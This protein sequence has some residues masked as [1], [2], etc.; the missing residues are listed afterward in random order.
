MS[1]KALLWNKDHF[2]G[3]A[4]YQELAAFPTYR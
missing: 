3:N 4:T 1:G 2:S